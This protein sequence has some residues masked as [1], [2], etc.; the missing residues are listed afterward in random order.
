MRLKLRVRR[1]RTLIACLIV[2]TSAAIIFLDRVAIHWFVSDA[3][4]SRAQWQRSFRA[5]ERLKMAVMAAAIRVSEETNGR[6]PVQLSEIP[7]IASK[8]GPDP[9]DM[10]GTKLQ[11][12]RTGPHSFVLTS[13]GEDQRFGT[14]DD[15]IHGDDPSE[16]EEEETQRAYMR[17]NSWTKSPKGSPSLG[18]TE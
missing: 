1:L 9:I 8:Y 5:D 18:K 14:S 7:Y 4:R 11:Y 3:G 17:E 12:T 2:V 10:W 16:L 6:L 15:L 13:A